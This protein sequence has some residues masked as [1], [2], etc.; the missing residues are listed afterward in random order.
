M[1]NRFGVR[2]AVLALVL[3][4]VGVSVWLNMLQLDRVWERLAEIRAAQSRLEES[5]V[6]LERRVG[7]LGQAPAAQ[8]GVKPAPVA[9]DDWARPGVP[10]KRA[11]RPMWIADPTGLPDFA[12]GGVITE[13]L[14]QDLSTITPYVG[15]TTVTRRVLELVQERLAD[16]NPKT[17]E[18]E[19][20]LAEAWQMDPSGLW[21]RVKI[22]DDANWSDGEPVTATDVKFTIDLIRNPAYG[23]TRFQSQFEPVSGVTSVSPKVV[24]FAF[25][26]ALYTNEF[27]TL[28]VAPLPAHFYGKLTPEQFSTSTGMLM[29]SGPYMVPVPGIENQW[30]PGKPVELV[31]NPRRRGAKPPADSFRFVVVKSPEA[32]FAAIRNGE[33]DLVRGGPEHAA[34]LRADAGATQR[35]FAWPMLTV[36]PAVIVWNCGNRK[37]GALSCFS[38]AKVRRAMTQALDRERMNREFFGGVGVVVSGPFSPALP[39]CDPEIRPWTFD[40]NAANALLDQTGLKRGDGGARRDAVGRV[41]AFRIIGQRAMANADGW[42]AYLRDQAALLGASCTVDL[43]DGAAYVAAIKGHDFDGVIAAWSPDSPEP[44]VHQRYH[45]AGIAQGGDNDG[46]WSN[47][48][49]DRLIDEARRT[50]DPDKRA[51][52]WRAF[53]RVLHDEQPATFIVSRPMIMLTSGRIANINMYPLGLER[54]EMY[55]RK[56]A[57]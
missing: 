49:A 39:A 53:H 34:A 23:A 11:Q 52:V 26:D 43:L 10:I 30:T 6:R 20:V 33:V 7:E 25:S 56:S 32:R 21:L 46:Q 31:R 35:V 45:S 12:Y 19:G 3:I 51:A 55:L 4:G 36:G 24:E 42:S 47:P 5:I 54:T 22:R 18:M 38:D 37:D 41:L 17:L 27:G 13:G 40:V 8:P 50:L 29:G 48:E 14:E 1:P 57:E 16:Y 28:R 15:T 9:A 44:N 2:H